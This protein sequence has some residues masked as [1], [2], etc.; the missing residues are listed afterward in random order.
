LQVLADYYTG[1]EKRAFF[2]CKINFIEKDGYYENLKPIRCSHRTIAQ[3][4][5]EIG[6]NYLTVGNALNNG[7]SVNSIFQL[8]ER[9]QLLCT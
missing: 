9:D 2:F 8:A 3:R 5:T 6:R 4:F 1:Y 7:S